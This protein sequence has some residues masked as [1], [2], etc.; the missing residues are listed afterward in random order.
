MAIRIGINGFGRIGRSVFR[1]AHE[2]F[3]NIEIVGI[4]DLVPAPNLAYLV[5][6]DSIHGRFSKD[7]QSK[8]GEF[9]VEGKK[10]TMK[11]TWL[12]KLV[13]N[14]FQSNSANFVCLCLPIK[15]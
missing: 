9:S 3:N 10:H 15:K 6:Y 8:E 1:L 2:K 12:I 4:N 11:I 7:I 5:K 14:N 13:N